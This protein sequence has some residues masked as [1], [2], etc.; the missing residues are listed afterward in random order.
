M[1]RECYIW[2]ILFL[3]FCE[4]IEKHCNL[5]N[6]VCVR[7]NRRH[8]LMRKSHFELAV[9]SCSEV[10]PSVR[11]AI[12]SS[13]QILNH[14]ADVNERKTVTCRE[15]GLCTRMSRKN[16]NNYK[17]TGFFESSFCSPMI[18]HFLI[19]IFTCLTSST[20]C[21]RKRSVW[22][23]GCK[24]KQFNH[25]KVLRFINVFKIVIGALKLC[26]VITKNNFN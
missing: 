15:R 9:I 7:V 11:A 3:F 14:H 18:W 10:L 26:F 8:K 20:R 5:F 25:N 19:P 17:T 12:S 24:I 1:R 4:D 22:P 13:H 6:A 16:I 2:L 21:R 23:W